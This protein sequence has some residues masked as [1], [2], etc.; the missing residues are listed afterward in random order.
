MNLAGRLQ[1]PPYLKTYSLHLLLLG[2]IVALCSKSGTNQAFIIL[3]LPA[4]YYARHYIQRPNLKHAPT[5]L[6]LA[7]FICLWLPQLLALPDAINLSE[8]LRV[9]ASYPRFLL[10]GLFIL[11]FARRAQAPVL[12]LEKIVFVVLSWWC[13]DACAQYF[14]GYNLFGHPKE[15]AEMTGMFYPYNSLAHILA[16]FSPLYLSFLWKHRNHRA[17]VLSGLIMFYAVILLSGVRVAWIMLFIS[18]L[19]LVPFLLFTA[20]NHRRARSY[21]AVAGLALGATTYLS[22]SFDS[23]VRA[24]FDTTT[25]LFDFERESIA[26]ATSWRTPIWKTTL[27]V[28]ED[29][30]VNGIG[31]RGFRYVYE[32]YA[33]RDKYFF[34]V[35]PTHPHLFILEVLA[36][37]GGIGLL[38]YLLCFGLLLRHFMRL[39]PM[40][41]KTSYPFFLC[42]FVALFPLNAH[43]AFYGSYWSSVIWLSVT[44]LCAQ[45]S[46]CRDEASHPT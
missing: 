1:I 25:Q 8:A 46:Q 7:L 35:A 15:P 33:A 45:L 6:L 18:V 39:T 21:M 38:G 37:T 20:K 26:D 32:S 4:L 13:V 9:F 31:P 12:P 2:M 36:E 29:H 5:R 40:E 28:C 10:V 43:M 19:C 16:T 41:R 3:M 30:P 42:V 23:A 44:L 17:L 34:E 14:L 11:Y 27:G 24:R 22:L